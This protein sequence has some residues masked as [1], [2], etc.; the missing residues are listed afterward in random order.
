VKQKNEFLMAAVIVNRAASECDKEK[1]DGEEEE[2]GRSLHCR[3]A[4][5]AKTT[6]SARTVAKS[7]LQWRSLPAPARSLF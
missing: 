6:A 3:T 2:C 4:A 5:P 1:G 7:S